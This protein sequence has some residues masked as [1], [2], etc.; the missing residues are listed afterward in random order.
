MN[1][2][3]TVILLACA[4]IL[5]GLVVS[6]SL[7][8]QDRPRDDRPRLDRPER[9]E[10][11]RAEDRESAE[12]QRAERERRER[13]MR[14]EGPPRPPL[15][16]RR[17]GEHL[18]QLDLMMEMIERMQ[19]ICFDPPTAA[20]IAIGGLKDGVRRRPEAAAEG[21]EAALKRVKTLGLRNAIHL[22]LKDLYKQMGKEEKVVQHLRAMIEENDEII[23]HHERMNR[24]R[25]EHRRPDDRPRDRRHDDDDDDD[26]D[27]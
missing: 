14:R 26:D 11:A 7:A 3:K 2:R 6:Y 23:Q 17:P 5:A 8:E 19:R 9:E 13:E 1:G 22:T 4:T 16:H 20:M 25:Q 10:R 21:L 27:D 24:E 12:H 15:G 18:E